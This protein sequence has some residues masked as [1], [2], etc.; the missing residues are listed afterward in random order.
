MCLPIIGAVV[1]GIGSAMSAMMASAQ[2]SAQAKLQ[3]RQAEIERQAGAWQANQATRKA[4]R[5]SG[6]QRAGAIAS[7]LSLSGSETDVALSSA[8]EAQR[9]IDAIRW[10]AASKADTLQYEAQVS[11]MN[12]KNNAAGAIFGFLTPVING[13]A[14][15]RS[16]FS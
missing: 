8:I 11:R 2:A 6:A 9:D 15:Y 16:Q 10:N 3:E 1:S 13:V 4:D 7:G 5:I 12:A 14:K